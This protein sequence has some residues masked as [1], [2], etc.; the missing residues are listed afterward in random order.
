MAAAHR[1]ALTALRGRIRAL[2]V[3]VIC[4]GTWP[5]EVRWAVDRLE[6]RRPAR[7]SR[8]RRRWLE[9]SISVDL[10]PRDDEDF[11]LAVA[12][13]PYTICGTGI[14]G[15]D[16]VDY[17]ANDTGT[18]AWFAL[19]GRSSRPRPSSWRPTTAT[20]GASSRSRGAE[21][22]TGPR[23]ILR[24]GRC[25]RYA[26]L[27]RFAGAVALALRAREE[28]RMRSARTGRG[29]PAAL[30]AAFLLAVLTACTAGSTTSQSASP[31]SPTSAASA[32]SPTPA[33]SAACADAA[34]LKASLQALTK[35]QPLQDGLTAVRA[36]LNNVKTSL[37]Q[38][39]KSA[40]AAL[41][42]AV[43]QVKSALAQ[44]ETA[45]KGVTVDNLPAAGP[46]ISGALSQVASATSA[47]VATI[48]QSCPGT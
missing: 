32:A 46:R 16:R 25:G 6:A 10:D 2:C 40:S 27:A 31:T 8:W 17:D 11:A 23:R 44:L 42:P 22:S 15:R 39:E 19:T 48:A 3:D 38:A 13:A 30:V 37:G 7:W 14:D 43:A 24:R 18:S 12:V 20:P 1:G 21:P 45:T 36:A 29:V 4:D 34:A 35:V 9:P 33:T 26:R 5:D 28:E 47:L 41:Q